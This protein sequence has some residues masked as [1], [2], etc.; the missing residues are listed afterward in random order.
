MARQQFIIHEIKSPICLILLLECCANLLPEMLL[1]AGFPR[2]KYLLCAC[3]SQVGKIFHKFIREENIHQPKRTLHF[4]LGTL[5][6][7]F[8]DIFDSAC[9]IISPYA[10]LFL[11]VRMIRSTMSCFLAFQAPLMLSLVQITQSCFEENSSHSTWKMSS[12]TPSLSSDTSLHCASSK[13]KF[14]DLVGRGRQ[15]AVGESSKHYQLHHKE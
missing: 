3:I 5:S 7:W 6:C 14:E 10:F 13:F 8:G 12:A 11:S 15:Q 9:A 4:F 2:I 1:V